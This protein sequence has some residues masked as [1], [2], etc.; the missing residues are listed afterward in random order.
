MEERLGTPE[1][2][3]MRRARPRSW[4]EKALAWLWRVRQGPPRR[5]Y[6]SSWARAAAMFLGEWDRQR[7]R[8]LEVYRVRKLP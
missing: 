2:I 8:P 4:W 7:W 1:L 3:D 5:L 6:A